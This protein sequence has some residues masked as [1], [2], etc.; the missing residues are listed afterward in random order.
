MPLNILKESKKAIDNC[1]A[2]LVIAGQ[3]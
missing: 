3:V 2:V 1:D